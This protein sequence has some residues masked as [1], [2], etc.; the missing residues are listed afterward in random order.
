M[1]TVFVAVKLIKW[2]IWCPHRLSKELQQKDK[3]IESLHTKLQQRPET[4]SSCHGLSETTDQSDRTSLVSDEYRTTE[5]LE[6]CSD[7]DGREYREQHRMQVP[8]HGPGADGTVT[9]TSLFF[10]CVQVSLLFLHPPFP[11]SS[12]ST[13]PSSSWTSQVIQQL[14][15]HA[16][17]SPCGSEQSGPQ[18][19][20]SLRKQWFGKNLKKILIFF[21]LFI[22]SFSSLAPLAPFSEPVSPFLPVPLGLDIWGKEVTSDPGPGHCLWSLSGQSWTLC[23]DRGTNSS[24]VRGH[25][26]W[27]SFYIVLIELKHVEC[28]EIFFEKM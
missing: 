16:F 21:V 17:L 2:L 6:L 18:R 28:L 14:S 5:D 11:S 20:G 12:P 4:P 23:T 24:G 25:R 8:G 19:Y 3:I 13:F 26:V 22:S 27:R 10:L 1:F 9:A 15:Q 7:L